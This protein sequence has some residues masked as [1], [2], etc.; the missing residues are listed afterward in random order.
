MGAIIKNRLLYLVWG[1]Y[2]CLLNC[3]KKDGL[4][5][6]VCKIQVKR[7]QLLKKGPNFELHTCLLSNPLRSTMQT[8]FSHDQ[9]MRCREVFPLKIPLCPARR[10]TFDTAEDTSKTVT[11]FRGAVLHVAWSFFF[12]ATIIMVPG[13]LEC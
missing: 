9:L 7:K 13:A 8:D 4:Q 12:F 1:Y 11:A 6:P 3:R 10:I 2:Y 5:L